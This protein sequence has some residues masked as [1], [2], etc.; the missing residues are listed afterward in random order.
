MHAVMVLL[1]QELRA[2]SLGWGPFAFTL[3]GQAGTALAVLEMQARLNA[4]AEQGAALARAARALN[5]RLDLD[6]VLSTLCREA[7]HALGGDLAGVYLGDAARGGLAVAGRRRRRGVGLVELHDQTR[8]G[9][10][11]PGAAPSTGEP[12]ISNDFQ[13]EVEVPTSDALRRHRDRGVWCRCAG[14]AS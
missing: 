6:S 9:S 11:R 14:T 8:R 3:C 13:H 10:G 5:A 12:T 1:R 7:D 4:R 2:F